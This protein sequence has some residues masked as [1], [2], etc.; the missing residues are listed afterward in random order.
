MFI[1][2]NLARKGLMYRGWLCWYCGKFAQKTSA[3]QLFSL[4]D[5]SI[6]WFA[7]DNRVYTVIYDI[8]ERHFV[9]TVLLLLWCVPF[10]ICT[11]CVSFIMCTIISTLSVHDDDMTWRRFP[12]YFLWGEFTGDKWIPVTKGRYYGDCAGLM[13][14]WSSCW[15]NNQMASDLKRNDAH[16][17]SL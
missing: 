16:V 9:I 4:D 15:T 1:L 17:T 10:I 3:S 5:G 7:V 14:A 2:K 8:N 11:K 6:V 12:H 13:L